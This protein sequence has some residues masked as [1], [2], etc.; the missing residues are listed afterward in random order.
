MEDLTMPAGR[1]PL[2]IAEQVDRLRGS[3]VAKLRLRV[4]LENLAGQIGIAQAC[5][6]LGIE[7]SWFFDLK[8]ESLEH[9][10]RVL[11]P[12]SPGRRPSPERTP[13]QEQIAELK[14]RV[15][16]LELELKGAHLGEE[17]ARKGLSRPK[18]PANYPAKKASR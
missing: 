8:H 17:L 15:R 18:A 10:A 2:S 9:L 14:E 1:R 5:A 6:E 12:S 16:H 3:P 7:Q 4:I 13:E 11:E